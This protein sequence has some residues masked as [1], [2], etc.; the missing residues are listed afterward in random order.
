MNPSLIISHVKL[1]TYIGLKFG[2]L[3]ELEM[4]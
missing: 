2:V 1:V 3:S 4:V